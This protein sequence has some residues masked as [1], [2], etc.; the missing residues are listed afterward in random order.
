[1]KISLR[2]ANALQLE[3]NA[4]ISKQQV[5]HILE[6]NE[7]ETNIEESINKLSSEFMNDYNNKLKLF[8]VICE[9]RNKIGQANA[10]SGINSLLTELASITNKI[11]I[12]TVSIDK[13]SSYS[14]E[15]VK[16]RFEKLIET[17]KA[18]GYSHA[19]IVEVLDAEDNDSL[20]K[21]I[22]KLKKSKQK[23]QDSLLELNIRTEINL[24]DESVEILQEH[25][26][27]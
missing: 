23:I 11:K 12:S 14:L 21:N 2:K 26:L 20:K 22:T 9:I 6:V 1:M 25:D 4:Y 10:E 18:G 16:K 19:F 24:S 27:I 13:R 15:N 3:I 8:D 17:S 5:S 7:F